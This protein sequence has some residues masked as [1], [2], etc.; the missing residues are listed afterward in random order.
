M[1]KAIRKKKKKKS[2]FDF[3]SE[4]YSNFENLEGKKRA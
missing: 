1:Q 3:Y 4:I 2:L